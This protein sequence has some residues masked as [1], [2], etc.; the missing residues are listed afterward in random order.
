MVR[1]QPQISSPPDSKLK[2]MALGSIHSL[3]GP[4]MLTLL[5]GYLVCLAVF[6]KVKFQIEEEDELR[7]A[8]DTF[9][10]CASKS[11]SNSTLA[12]VVHG[13]G[14]CLKNSTFRIRMSIRSKLVYEALSWPGSAL[15]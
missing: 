1:L 4:V 2:F 12:Y 6:S 13:D 14:G 5:Q 8:F 7:T 11:Q 3:E 9:L 10:D 15:A